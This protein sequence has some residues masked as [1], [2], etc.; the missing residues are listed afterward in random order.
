MTA[1][2]L[3]AVLTSFNK[4]ELMV[5]LGDNEENLC[6]SRKNIAFIKLDDFEN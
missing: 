4:D 2:Q 1:K 3:N 5:S 6:I